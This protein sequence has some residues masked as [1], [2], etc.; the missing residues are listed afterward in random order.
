MN[1]EIA[2]ILKGYL[3]VD[4]D[5][6]THVLRDT[7]ELCKSERGVSEAIVRLKD[8]VNDYSSRLEFLDKVPLYYLILSYAQYK[9]GKMPDSVD[10]ASNA[11]QGFKQ[12]DQVR[13]NVISLWIRALIFRQSD[14]IEAALQDINVG[15]KLIE[16]ELGDSKR[17]SHYQEC[18][19]CETIYS[20]MVEYR[21]NLEKEHRK[22]TRKS[23]IPQPVASKRSTSSG[24]AGLS[25]LSF[26]IYTVHA[27]LDG[28][29]AYEST[30][31]GEVII[32]TVII[33]GRDHQIYSLRDSPE[34]VLRPAVYRWLQV[35][36]D[37]MENA[38]PV[39]IREGDCVLVID[40]PRGD[41]R[42][43]YKDI[44][45]IATKD[46]DVG[47]EG[48]ALIKRFTSEGL[49]SESDTPYAPIPLKDVSIRGLAI[50][51]AK[52]KEL[53]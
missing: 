11:I 39:S 29:I 7:L 26:P 28:E 30:P 43:R 50:A 36:G 20:R 9:W 5:V 52:P 34:L 15:I 24:E 12:Q 10:S 38:S 25:Y 2:S 6:R 45:V 18:K 37:S 16:R 32:K 21:D 44:V 35:C 23:A 40:V 49:C 51:V 19:D 48:A 1:D 31:L 47:F 41:Y 4:E 13:N 27:G 3:S 53:S 17:T 22:R 8:I 33:G 14:H 46:V 42:P